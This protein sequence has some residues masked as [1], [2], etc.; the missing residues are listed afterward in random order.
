MTELLTAEAVG[1]RVAVRSE[2]ERTVEM[3]LLQ[4]GEVGNTAEGRERFTRGAFRG[5]RPG[6]VS[7]EAIGPHGAQPGVRLV[8]RA[9]SVDEREDGAYAVFRVS[10]VPAG[11]ELLELVRDGVYSRASVVFEPVQS[12]SAPDGVVE[13]LRVNLRRVGIVERGAYQSAEVL[14]VR[15]EGVTAMTTEPNPPTEPTP[16]PPTEPEPAPTVRVLSR[17]ADGSELDALRADMLRRFT[18]L[19]AG[20]GRGVGPASPLA[21]FATFAAFADAAFADP[22]VAPLLAR[23]L[24]DQ[25]TTDNPGVMQPSWIGEIGGLIARPRPAIT[26]LGG[27]R[28]LGDSGMELDWPYLDPTI[29]LDSVI[30]VQVAE[31]TEINSV[32]VKILKGTAPIATYAGGSD[33]SYQLIRRSRP[34]YVDAYLRVLSIAYARE[35]EAAFEHAL[36]A[37][38][39]STIVI[40]ASASA[41]QVRAAYFAASAQVESATGEPATVALASTIEWLRLGGLPGLFPSAYGTQNIAGTAQASTLTINV[42]G[43]PVIRAPFL[44]GQETIITNAIA[45]GW[46]EDGPFPISAEDVAKLGRDVAIWGM[47]TTAVQVPKGIVKST[48]VTADDADAG[49]RKR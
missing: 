49:T 3:R 38:A 15:S 29:D 46:H 18:A 26:A 33:V 48:L 14:A 5:T 17:G 11:D 8:G 6:A 21:R 22:S 35:T 20:A 32:K 45:A 19:E 4:W 37:G 1:D 44:T 40:G 23:T 43:L 24:V 41:D 27:P 7:L 47:G 10:R 34:A 31:K 39:A 2:G 30:A 16:D 9:E 36:E 25:I 13:R 28:S 12:R 42:S